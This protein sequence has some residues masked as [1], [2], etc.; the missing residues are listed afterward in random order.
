MGQKGNKKIGTIKEQLN[1]DKVRKAAGTLEK[2][3][4]L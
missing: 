2:I 4:Q 1:T 3:A